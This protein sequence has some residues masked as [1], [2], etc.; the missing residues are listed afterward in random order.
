[1]KK[2]LSMLLLIALVLSLMAPA[3]AATYSSGAIKAGKKYTSSSAKKTDSDEAVVLPGKHS[4]VTNEVRYYIVDGGGNMAT[5]GAYRSNSTRFDAISLSYKSGMMVL[6]AY[7]NL[8]IKASS[9]NSG[10]VAVSGSWEP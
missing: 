7:Y 1:M 4:P 10:T 3:F 5:G 6:N 9:T 8:R 2:F